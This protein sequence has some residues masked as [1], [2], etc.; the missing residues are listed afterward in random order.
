VT[1]P[2]DL[3]LHPGI[4]AA[5]R[6]EHVVIRDNNDSIVLKFSE[7]SVLHGWLDRVLNEQKPC[8]ICG[9]RLRDHSESDRMQCAETL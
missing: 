2:A 6:G 8:I 4:T 3:T 1:T 7:A 5:V 9:R